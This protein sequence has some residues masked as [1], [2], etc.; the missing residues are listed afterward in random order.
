MVWSVSFWFWSF[1]FSGGL[2]VAGGVEGE[3]AQEFAGADV[4]DADVVVLHEEDDALM[5]YHH[6][7]ALHPGLDEHIPG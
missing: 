2:V 5:A 6:G 3:V 7:G 1:W 4:D